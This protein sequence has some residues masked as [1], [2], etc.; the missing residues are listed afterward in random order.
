MSHQKNLLLILLVVV[1]L[2]G[3]MSVYTVDQRQRGIVLRLGEIVRTDVPPGLH[4]K[5]PLVTS[6]RKIDTR[7]LT[8]DAEPERFL[9]SE[10]KNVIVDFFV[11]W[12]IR[13]IGK[14][15]RATGGDQRR[16]GLRL[17][18]V[19]KKGLRAEFGK[20]TIQEV[21]SGDRAEIMSLV[22][23]E[24]KAQAAEFGIELVD[25]RVRRIDLPRQV[26]TSVYQR[27]EAERQR[28]AKSFR[29]RGAE[30]AEK[31][32]ADADRQRQVILAEAYR[33]AE[34][35]RGEGDAKAAEI[36]A[37]AYNKDPEFYAFYRSLGAYRET[38]NSKKDVIVLQPDSQFF[39]YYKDASGGR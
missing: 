17:S 31:I 38:F 33:T 39:K 23:K 29:A 18:Q 1:L 16:A 27:M 4:F 13:D 32:R 5:L 37:K 25:I 6:V 35:L 22:A 24:A 34:T 30:T 10:K 19:I 14:F 2:L 15:Y 7:I 3:S 9:T 8:L 11:K 21:V 12:R 20:R 28:V 26:S 36:Y